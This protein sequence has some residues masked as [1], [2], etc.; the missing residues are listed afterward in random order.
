MSV[1]HV[2]TIVVGAGILGLAVAREVLARRPRERVLVVEREPRPAAH[3]SSHSSGV[4]HAGVY[5][6]P[7]SLKA[8]LCVDG[9]ALMYAYCERHGIDAR[10]IGKLIIALRRDELPALDELERRARANGVGG[11]RRLDAD[12]LRAIE[13][14]A[15]GIAALH[16]PNTGIVDFGAVCARLA[17]DLREAGAELRPRFEVVAVAAGDRT[18]RLRAGSGDE[19]QGARA[20]F[21]AGL[22]SDRLA[23]LAG[24]DPDPRIVPF[25][26][27]YMRLRPERRELVRGLIYPVPDPSL[28]FLGVHLT[29]RID[30]EVL[31]GPSALLAGARD[32]Y[33]LSTL[34]AAD[35]RDTAT[36]PGT[37]RMA[38]RWWRTGIHEL[39][40]AISREAFAAVAAQY[41]PDLRGE[42]LQ[43][44]FAGVRAQAVGRDGRLVDDFLLSATPRA[45]HVRNAPSPA[46]T[47]SLALA[48]KIADAADQLP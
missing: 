22:W 7:G 13:P 31:L 32:G 1:D 8:R 45:I 25:R 33:R 29:P 24:T 20:I 14:H 5:Y 15:S 21:C 28:P 26:G 36:W 37:W 16:S 44:A 38:R 2:D 41:V 17:T 11:V 47:S 48:A 42:D 19:L 10:A 4:I 18:I 40:L 12:G 34:R 39:R 6:A 43:P 27:G 30:G 35:I 3:Q 46:A 9:A 23:V